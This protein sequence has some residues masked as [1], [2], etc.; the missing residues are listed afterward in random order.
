MSSTM[1]IT[2]TNTGLALGSYSI[3]EWAVGLA[4]W[5]K[6]LHPGVLVDL[7][8]TRVSGTEMALRRVNKR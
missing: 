8:G 5:L 4:G 3:D 7:A 2:C 1:S 6:A